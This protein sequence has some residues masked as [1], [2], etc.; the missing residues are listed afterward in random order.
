MCCNECW[1]ADMPLSTHS[2][3]V[4]RGKRPISGTSTATLGIAV[5]RCGRSILSVSRSATS[6]SALS[7]AAPHFT[8]L[9]LSLAGTFCVLVC[10]L[11]PWRTTLNIQVVSAFY[12]R[13][14]KAPGNF[15]GQIRFPARQWRRG[16]MQLRLNFLRR[17][18][19]VC[20]WPASSHHCAQMLLLTMLFWCLFGNALQDSIVYE[21]AY[22]WVFPDER[23][24][25][26]HPL[27]V[28]ASSLLDIAKLRK[29]FRVYNNDVR[30]ITL[31]LRLIVRIREKPHSLLMYFLSSARRS[32]SF[33]VTNFGISRK[34]VCDFLWIE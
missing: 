34:L 5:F 30:E 17:C 10:P 14:W 32:K 22:S 12:K 9:L 1:I 20:V 27:P 3:L 15:V 33:N 13:A 26:F 16:A 19:C 11:P 28:L 4:A 8:S 21:P 29:D 2:P 31:F 18:V 7:C 23:F 6:F 25:S 24:S